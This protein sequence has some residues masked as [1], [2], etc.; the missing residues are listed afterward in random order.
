MRREKRLRPFF[1][2][3]RRRLWLLTDE[4]YAE[5]RNF[6]S[7]DGVGAIIAFYILVDIGFNRH[8]QRGALLQVLPYYLY[9]NDF[10]P[11]VSHLG[12]PFGAA[13]LGAVRAARPRR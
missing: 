12:T 5:E 13:L 1:T 3:E 8:A 10:A 2:S 7:L 9:V 6:R 4:K 11:N